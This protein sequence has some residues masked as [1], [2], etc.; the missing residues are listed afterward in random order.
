MVCIFLLV[1]QRIHSIQVS[2]SA[3]SLL[4]IGID[5][6]MLTM[7]ESMLSVTQALIVLSGRR[8]SQVRYLS[9]RLLAHAKTLVV[10]GLWFICVYI[11]LPLF[12]LFMVPSK[13]PCLP[14]QHS[15]IPQTCSGR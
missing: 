11:S 2:K 3:G 6:E 13:A 7:P 8:S 9:Q 1:V 4:L 14:Q 12:G 10:L 15:L 5:T